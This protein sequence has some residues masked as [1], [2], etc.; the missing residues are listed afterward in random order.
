[1]GDNKNFLEKLKIRAAVEIKN[2]GL[3]SG[4]IKITLTVSKNILKRAIKW[5][6]VIG[7]WCAKKKSGFKG[8]IPYDKANVEQMLRA[9]QRELY[10]WRKV[11]TLALTTGLRRSELLG[12]EWKHLDFD[13]GILDVSQSMIHALEG[14]IIVKQPETKKSTRNVALPSSKHEMTSGMNG[15]SDPM[16]FGIRRL[17]F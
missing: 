15:T 11:I 10:H 16:I 3:V 17:Q 12:L 6:S 1:M 13:T 8:I 5:R 4:T 14:E 2:G 9:L 7:Q